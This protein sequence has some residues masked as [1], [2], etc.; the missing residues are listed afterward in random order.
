MLNNGPTSAAWGN[1]AM[2]SAIESRNFF[3]GKS[4]R[5]IA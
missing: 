3:P 1:I 4:S 2:A 5:A